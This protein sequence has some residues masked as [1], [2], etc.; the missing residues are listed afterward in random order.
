[1][2]F[3]VKKTRMVWLSVM[4]KLADMS[5]VSTEFTNVTDRRT[6]H[7][8]TGQAALMHSIARKK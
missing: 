6:P 2:T 8:G 4:K 3:G 5:A 7:D 1:M